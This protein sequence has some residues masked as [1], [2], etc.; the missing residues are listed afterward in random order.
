MSIPCERK[1]VF[2]VLKEPKIKITI[3]GRT[4]LVILKGG[5]SNLSRMDTLYCIEV[6]TVK[7]M[8]NVDKCLREAALQLLGVNV[9]N[10]CAS[11]PILLTNL[12]K[13]HYVL[14][15]TL[16]PNSECLRFLMN[17]NKY[18]SF[19]NALYHMETTICRQG[20][21]TT[22]FGSPP[23]PPSSIHI[24]EDENEDSGDLSQE[25]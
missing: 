8:K 5:E 16:D 24:S 9:D 15:I 3:E 21:V 1:L 23:T 22:Y 25:S 2:V 14:F 6:K 20:C 7:G 13:M 11:P 18:T 12:N 19:A 10:H 17:I 4:D